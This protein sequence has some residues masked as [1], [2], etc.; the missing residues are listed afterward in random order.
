MTLIEK[1]TQLVIQMGDLTRDLYARGY[2]F[3]IG[4]WYRPPELAELYAK[5]GRGI[6]RSLHCLSLAFDLCLYRGEKYLTKSED[7]REAGELWESYS[8]QEF[9]CAWGG[10]FLKPDGNHFSFVHE[11]R[12]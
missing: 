7:Y 11:N 12:R 6:A 9:T 10:R 2:N 4:E 1:Q 5:E 8:T 3:R